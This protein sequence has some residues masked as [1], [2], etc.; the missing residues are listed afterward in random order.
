MWWF[1]ICILTQM[2]V[3]QGLKTKL[4]QLPY[5]DTLYFISQERNSQRY[6]GNMSEYLLCVSDRVV[7]VQRQ[8]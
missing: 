8:K 6:K 1:E 4:L 7:F 5:Q 3:F 2:K